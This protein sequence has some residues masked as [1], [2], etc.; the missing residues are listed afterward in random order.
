MNHSWWQAT[1]PILQSITTLY[2][3]MALGFFSRRKALLAHEAGR[4]FNAFIY[5]FALPALFFVNI[6][7]LEIGSIQPVLIIGSVAPILLVVLFLSIL[8]SFGVLSKD[9]YVLLSLAVTFSSS[10][11]FG[12]PFFEEAMGEK[13]LSLAVI[14]SSFLAPTGIV[15]S[16][17]LFELATRKERGWGVLGKVF[18]SPLIV[19]IAL[20][21][22]CSLLNIRISFILKAGNFLGKTALGLAVFSLGMF[23]HDNLSWKI[24]HKG[25]KYTLFRIFSLPMATVLVLVFFSA[26]SPD[27]RMFLLLQSGIPAAISLAVFSQRYQYKIPEVS[28]IVIMTSLLSFITLNALALVDRLL[29]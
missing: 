2:V 25:F 23:I 19:S 16:L 3:L 27:L 9:R 11:F 4:H 26:F 28:G 5:Y 22:L 12:I 13:G 20:G 1:I 7:K 17:T 15:L 29:W 10:A 21:F 6:S 8:K 18:L 14:T 24:I